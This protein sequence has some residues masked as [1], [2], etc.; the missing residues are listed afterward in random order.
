M[1]LSW[2]LW[3]LGILIAF[4][5]GLSVFDVYQIPV[6]IDQLKNLVGDNWAAKSLFVSLALVALSKLF[7]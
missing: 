6:L 7:N 3:L 4:V 2:L 1:N 5:V